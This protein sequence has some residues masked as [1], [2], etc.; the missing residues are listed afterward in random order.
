MPNASVNWEV[1][2][3]RELDARLRDLPTKLQARALR[4]AVGAGARV[5]RDDAR[6]RVHDKR[7][8]FVKLFDSLHHLKHLK[9][10]PLRKYSYRSKKPGMGD[11]LSSAHFR[12]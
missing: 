2:G 4:G 9:V 3:L 8:H 11:W 1:A 10:R 5:I 6:T 12:I 7:E